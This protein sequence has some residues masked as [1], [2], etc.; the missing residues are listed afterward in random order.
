MRAVP[1]EGLCL[2]KCCSHSAQMSVMSRPKFRAIP[3]PDSKGKSLLDD[4]D[5]AIGCAEAMM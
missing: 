1:E 5:F 2:V 3:Q 4:F